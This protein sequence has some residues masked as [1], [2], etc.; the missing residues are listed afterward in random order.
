MQKKKHFFDR[1]V[2]GLFLSTAGPKKGWS[3]YLI[4]SIRKETLDLCRITLIFIRYEKYPPFG[5]ALDKKWTFNCTTKKSFFL[6]HLNLFCQLTFFL[7][8]YF[9]LFPEN[10]RWLRANVFS[11]I[12]FK[13]VVYMVMTI[14]QNRKSEFSTEKFEIDANTF[15][16]F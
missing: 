4:A 2:E 15:T 1:A 5:P 13:L 3:S 7:A 12:C 10:S 16:K 9:H 6:A 14:S 11:R 8:S